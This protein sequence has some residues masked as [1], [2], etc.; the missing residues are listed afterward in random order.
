M[1]SQIISGTPP[2]RRSKYDQSAPVNGSDGTRDGTRY[3]RRRSRDQRTQQSITAA[4]IAAA[5]R[6]AD[7]D[8]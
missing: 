8:R 2:D 6:F 1:Y 4:D 3:S 7:E 5:R